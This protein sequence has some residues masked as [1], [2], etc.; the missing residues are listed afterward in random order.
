M[1]APAERGSRLRGRTLRF[2]PAARDG[3]AW[4][5]GAVSF[6]NIPTLSRLQGAL[7]SAGGNRN[8]RSA[9]RRLHRQKNRKPTQFMSHPFYNRSQARSHCAQHKK[10]AEGAHRFSLL[11]EEG[12]AKRR[13]MGRAVGAY[14]MREALP[15]KP[16]FEGDLPV[17][18]R[19]WREASEDRV[20][21]RATISVLCLK[22]RRAR[23]RSELGSEYSDSRD[24]ETSSG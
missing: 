3:A 16:P 13:M 1:S 11:R 14:K 20:A 17:D 10:C 15:I 8:R 23:P 18:G 19:R 21:R 2:Y 22:R 7:P 4:N 24:P 12:G 5:A 9:P 6:C